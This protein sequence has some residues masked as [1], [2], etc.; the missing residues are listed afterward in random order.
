MFLS[1]LETGKKAKVTDILNDKKIDKQRLFD[2]GVI[3]G[4]EI[5]ALYASPSGN[6]TAYL[7]RGTVFALRSDTASKIII[8]ADG[9][10]CP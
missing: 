5:C 2:L 10:V 8:K 3:P 4:T 7:I 9:S 6:I 1:E